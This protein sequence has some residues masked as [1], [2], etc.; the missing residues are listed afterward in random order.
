MAYA[1]CRQYQRTSDGALSSVAHRDVSG[2]LDFNPNS[3][4]NKS[5]KTQFKSK[6]EQ[7]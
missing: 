2:G 7:R 6:K 5:C 1:T 4:R 3:T